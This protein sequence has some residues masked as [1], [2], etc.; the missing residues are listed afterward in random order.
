MKGDRSKFTVLPL[1]KFGLM[2]ITRQRVRPEVNIS[3]AEKCP[4]C[5]GTG[6]ITASIQVSEDIEQMLK[7]LL[8]DQN[9]NNVTLALHPYL[10]SYFSRGVYSVRFKWFMKYHKWIKMIE[11]SSLPMT[12]YKFLNSEMEIIEID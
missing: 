6:Q 8:V 11:D 5:N 4:T 7:H 12:E 2:Q 9:E 10:Y 3:T 1:S